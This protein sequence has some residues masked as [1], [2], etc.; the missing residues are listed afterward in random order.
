MKFLV[1]N[2]LHYGDNV[3]LYN[4]VYSLLALAVICSYSPKCDECYSTKSV[5]VFVFFNYKIAYILVHFIFELSLS[6]LV[7]IRG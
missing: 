4:T 2:M 3:D 1:S 5:C 7:S 6:L